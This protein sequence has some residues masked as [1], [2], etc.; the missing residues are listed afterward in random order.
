MKEVKQKLVKICEIHQDK[1]ASCNTYFK[2]NQCYV[3][4]AACTN[5]TK[6]V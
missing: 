5:I 2:H 1:T 6:F 4:N 3:A